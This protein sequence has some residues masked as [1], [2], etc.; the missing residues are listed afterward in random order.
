VQ[1]REKLTREQANLLRKQK[2]VEGRYP[3]LFVAPGIAAIT[4]EKSSYIKNRAFDNI[5]YKEMIISF[6]KEFGAASRKDID[7][8]LFDK[9]SDV[10]DKKQK[11]KKLN[12]LLHEMSRI[13]QTI[14][15][16]G[17]RKN[18][19]WTLTGAS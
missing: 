7:E 17:S 3:N 12:N 6:I 13:D 10:L 18:P 8:L 5:H 19:Q 9:L 2:L 15:N 1:K 11:T 14:K 16:I 4:E